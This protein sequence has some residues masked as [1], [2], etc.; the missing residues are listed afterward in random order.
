MLRVTSWPAV[1]S[2]P[3]VDQHEKLASKP[4]APVVPRSR[5][6]ASTVNRDN[7][8]LFDPRSLVKSASCLMRVYLHPPVKQLRWGCQVTERRVANGK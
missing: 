8:H 7:Q 5:L 3:V 4:T 1:R 2:E 6:L